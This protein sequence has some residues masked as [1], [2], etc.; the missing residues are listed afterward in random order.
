MSRSRSSG[1]GALR[2]NYFMIVLIMAVLILVVIA[3]AL[4][5]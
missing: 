1:D 2:E 4:W 5:R 3:A